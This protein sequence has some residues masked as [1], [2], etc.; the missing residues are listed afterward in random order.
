MKRLNHIV[1]MLLLSIWSV[2]I[3]GCGDEGVFKD[4]NIETKSKSRS[5]SNLQKAPQLDENAVE[6]FQGEFEIKLVSTKNGKE[7]CQG[8]F[9]A[10][11]WSNQN[12]IPEG[13]MECKFAGEIDLAEKFPALAAEAMKEHAGYGKIV[14][15]VNEAIS[16]TPPQPA[17]LALV[18]DHNDFADF[19]FEEAASV[20]VL[21]EQTTLQDQGSFHLY[22]TST[23]DYMQ[24]ESGDTFDH[25]ISYVL[26]STGFENIPRSTSKIES[27]RQIWLNTKPITLLRIEIDSTLPDLLPGFVSRLGNLL[28]GPVKISIQLIGSAR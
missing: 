25:V 8:F 17:G 19:S 1:F 15:R 6:V 27:K 11:L 9:V 7:I 23:M 12:F 16:F 2:T 20:S 26:E 24:I 21:S 13:T 4:G 5:A 10:T 22:V 18:Q 28:Y 3:S 14:R